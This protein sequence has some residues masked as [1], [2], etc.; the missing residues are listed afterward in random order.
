MC[1]LYSERA[2]GLV[3]Y[4]T[5]AITSMYPYLYLTWTLRL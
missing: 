5:M 2:D 4:L 1:G 3:I